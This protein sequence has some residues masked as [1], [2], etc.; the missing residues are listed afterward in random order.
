MF[1][2]FCWNFAR[3]CQNLLELSE[4]LCRN[5]FFSFE[6]SNNIER[7]WLCHGKVHPCGIYSDNPVCNKLFSPIFFH[8]S[9][10]EK[11]PASPAS[12]ASSGKFRHPFPPMTPAQVHCDTHW[13]G[14][15]PSFRQGEIFVVLVNLKVSVI[16][17]DQKIDLA[18]RQTFPR[19]PIFTGSC[20]LLSQEA[21]ASFPMS[22]QGSNCCHFKSLIQTHWSPATSV[23]QV[24][25][26][27][28][29]LM[30]GWGGW[31]AHRCPCSGHWRAGNRV[32][33]ACT[34]PRAGFT[35]VVAYSLL[36]QH[37]VTAGPGGSQRMHWSRPV[38]PAGQLASASALLVHNLSG[39]R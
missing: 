14:G 39:N 18:H 24:Q 15:H 25:F 13:V 16:L 6:I 38:N 34:C 36:Y 21:V 5:Q 7:G 37:S 17:V 35:D 33:L 2:L 27:P 3:T 11:V 28:L 19:P 31:L 23:I 32:G 20:R 9:K 4:L 26:P 29:F 1:A 12:S 22:I 30:E 10:P 8:M